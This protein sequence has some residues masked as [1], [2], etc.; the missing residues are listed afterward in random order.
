MEGLRAVT[1]LPTKGNAFLVVGDL[2]VDL[3]GQLPRLPGPDEEVAMSALA[4]SAGGTA[5][6]TAVALARLGVRA[7]VLSA[8]GSDVLGDMLVRMLAEEGVD[9]RWCLRSS[10]PTGLCFAAV[11]P[12]G[13]RRLLTH[14]GANRDLTPADVA[15]EALAWADAVHMT[16]VDPAVAEAVVHKARKAGRPLSFD[17]GNMMAAAHPDT[18][19]RV[20]AAAWITFVSRTEARLLTGTT[21]PAAVARRLAG[22]GWRRTVLKLGEEGSVLLV[23]GE[24]GPHVPAF[25]VPVVDTIGAGDAFDA[26]FLW[27]CARGCEL[28]TCARYASAVAAMAIGAWG[29]Q[30][31]LPTAREVEAFVQ[32]RAAHGG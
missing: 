12:G 32:G 21:T 31:G 13:E 11:E 24:V 18:V 3:V 30:A 9:A 14:R 16:G 4:I 17:P 26:G 6:N 10:R 8:V 20:G 2:N 28:E 22:A 19:L 25:R 15:D 7:A 23:D 29:G 1:P 5:G 27:A